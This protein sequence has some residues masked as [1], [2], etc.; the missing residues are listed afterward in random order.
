M[1]SRSSQ[2]GWFLTVLF[3]M[4]NPDLVPD[5]CQMPDWLPSGREK[6]HLAPINLGFTCQPTALEIEVVEEPGPG[7]TWNTSPKSPCLDAKFFIPHL[8]RKQK[9][10]PCSLGLYSY[11]EH[12]IPASST[13]SWVLHHSQGPGLWAKWPLSL[14][15]GSLHQVS[16]NH[17]D[18]AKGPG[19]VPGML[20]DLTASP[21]LTRDLLCEI[22]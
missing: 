5:K 19:M 8:P 10:F 20:V 1:V 2:R 7:V 18:Q 22:S 9:A 21:S 14:A 15:G 13:E 12:L 4:T 16:F 11:L 17:M 6:D 3:C